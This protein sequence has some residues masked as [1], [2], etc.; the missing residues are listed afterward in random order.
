MP[1]LLR[2]IGAPVGVFQDHLRLPFRVIASGGD[3]LGQQMR[4]FGHPLLISGFSHE[5]RLTD[6]FGKLGTL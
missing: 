2:L 4:P 6:R 5:L 1:G 3:L